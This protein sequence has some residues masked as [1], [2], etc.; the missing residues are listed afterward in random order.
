MNSEFQYDTVRYPG[1]VFLQ[2]RPDRIGAMAI[3]HGVTPDR[4]DDCR[5]LELGCGDGASLLSIASSMPGAKCVGIDLS[6]PRISEAKEN[7]KAIGLSN[8]EFHQMDV[9]EFDHEHFGEFDFVIAHGLFSWVP[10]VVRE[11]LLEIYNSALARNGVGFISYNTFPGWHIRTVVR[12]A[13]H[14]FNRGTVQSIDQIEPTLDFL[15]VIATAAESDSIYPKIIQSELKA[16]EDRPLEVLFHDD[17]AEHNQPFYFSEFASMTEKAGL[18]F[19]SEARPLMQF[20]GKMGRDAREL[21]ESMSSDP[22]RREQCFDFLRGTRFRQ[23]L[24]C[25][26]E[27]SPRYLADPRAL[28]GL[29]FSTTSI[30]IDGSADFKD[31]ST[32]QFTAPKGSTITSNFGFTKT[33]LRFLAARAPAQVTFAEYFEL[34]REVF[35]EIG[36]DE[37]EQR[38]E[39]FR[40]HVLELF[41]AGVIEITCSA[42]KVAESVSERPQSAA[43]CR[44]QITQGSPYI[45]TPSGRTMPVPSEL[46]KRLV[47][48]L[49]GTRSIAE[50]AAWLSERNRSDRD[51]RSL[52]PEYILEGANQLLKNGVLVS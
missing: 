6:G 36:H 50:A 48:A 4:I 2:F 14:F 3:L 1:N 9:M 33:F 44:W 41:L 43:F 28:D 17:L 15:R 21:L 12:E 7:A 22:V 26:A 49:D 42:Y 13:G 38:S 34:A 39:L 37:F 24:I 25:H 18:A 52:T 10:A 23:T 27:A 20:T 31:D 11:K 47:L 32:V 19:I 40:M 30:P 5:V 35:K 45:T 29:F 51:R 16:I 8:V 46:A